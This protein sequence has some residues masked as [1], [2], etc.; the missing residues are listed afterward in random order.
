MEGELVTQ[1]K[2]LKCH[3]RV[4]IGTKTEL[5][6]CFSAWVPICDEADEQKPTGGSIDAV[7]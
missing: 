2:E 6:D 3:T 5:Q 7:F 1:T 4:D